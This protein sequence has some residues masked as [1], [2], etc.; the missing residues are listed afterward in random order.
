MYKYVRTL[1]DDA[2]V[3]RVRVGRVWFLDL[4]KFLKDN[5]SSIDI[6]AAWIDFAEPQLCY[7]IDENDNLM[8]KLKY[9]SF[10]DLIVKNGFLI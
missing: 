1:P 3:T 8:L 6:F 5:F 7:A 2:I 9:G 4:E 10:E